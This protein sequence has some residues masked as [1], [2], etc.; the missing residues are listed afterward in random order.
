M[1]AYDPF[2]NS[3]PSTGP[4][5][6]YNYG[7]KKKTDY[8]KYIKQALPILIIGIILF[9]IVKYTFLN[10]CILTINVENTEGQNITAISTITLNKIGSN[11]TFNFQYGEE[12]KV[13]KGQYNI[14]I[15][16]S[17]YNQY[18]D[19]IELKDSTYQLNNIILEQN[20]KLKIN[21]INFPQQ[22]F[23][24]QKISA[25]LEIENNS[26]NETYDIESIV[27]EADV[28]DWDFVYKDNFGNIQNNITF[29]PQI[30]KSVIVEFTVPED[31][32]IGNY[33]I[34]PRIKYKK[35]SSD[36]KKEFNIVNKP[37]INFRF[38]NLEGSYEI[39]KTSSYIITYEIDNSKNDLK[40]NDFKFNLE[41]DS[42][43]N[44]DC[45]NW[46]SVPQNNILVE[47]KS[48]ES[49]TINVFIPNN[50][51]PETLTGKLIINSS[52]LDQPHKE[53]IIID[54][55]EPEI[56]FNISLSKKEFDLDYNSTT[57]ETSI[58]TT[59]L[60]LNNN[61]DFDIFIDSINILDSSPVA[62]CNKF[63]YISPNYIRTITKKTNT[64]KITL[65]IY[66]TDTVYL[67]SLDLTSALNKIR[68]CDIRVKYKHPFKEDEYLEK[69]DSLTIY[70][71]N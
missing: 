10:N 16:A 61:N 53:D 60:Q 56:S 69:Q 34:Q 36:L 23:S 6:N 35:A 20:I 66:G 26:P 42:T 25:Q 7:N 33:K 5:S 28:K 58:E 41:L 59:E 29:L 22:I 64:N 27:F 45:N 47:S 44:P 30:K 49:G 51:K 18:S 17:N 52:S 13:K 40:I 63:I 8:S 46:F 67:S 15:R 4:Y 37:Q 38:T 3:G 71:D 39:A 11:K 57:K 50:A 24:G 55:I 31:I 14:K 65:T 68:T 70:I 43:L 48:K 9:I 1:S 19:N 62:D 54:L 2:S 32:K 21:A 12:I